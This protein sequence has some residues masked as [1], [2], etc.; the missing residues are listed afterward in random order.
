MKTDALELVCC[1]A[2]H[3]DLTLT[4]ASVSDDIEMGELVCGGCAK[5][6]SIENGLPHFAAPQELVGK[7]KIAYWAQTLIFSR[8]YEQT[9]IKPMSYVFKMSEAEAR[10]EYLSC[11]QLA[12]GDKLLEIAVGPGPNLRYLHQMFNGV[13]L[14]ALDLSTGMLQQCAKNLKTW[15]VEAHLFQGL[16]EALPF[17]SNSFNVVLQV[18]GLNTFRDLKQ[19][20]AEMLRVAKPGAQIVN[21]DEWLDPERLPRWWARALVRAVPALHQKTGPPLHLVP[22]E[23]VGKHCERIWNGCGY[24]LEFRK[25]ASP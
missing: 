16:A 15:S 10:R 21:V 2:C 1:P 9:V 12:P 4:E 5:V 7:N 13:K 6:Y 22:A 25:P 19:A 11:L 23:A 14:Y 17:K 24:R 8:T 18:G 3:H 20:L